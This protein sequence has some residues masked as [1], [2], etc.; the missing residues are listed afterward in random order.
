M[1]LYN[2]LY[3]LRTLSLRFFMVY[4]PRQ[5]R[6]GNY[7]VVTGKFIEKLNRGEALR[8]EGDGLQSRDFIHVNDIA[9]ALVLGYQSKVRGTVINVGNG[10]R[11]SVKALADIISSN[12]THV[13]AR[14]H[15]LRATLADT[16]RAKRLLSFSARKEMDVEIRKIAEQVKNGEDTM[17]IPVFWTWPETE[18][19]LTG[20]IE[21]W[22]TLNFEEKNDRIRRECEMNPKF[23]SEMVRLVRRNR[24]EEL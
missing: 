1:N 10:K 23:L 6:E 9:R 20:T 17:K 16:C 5:P 11:W 19:F 4:G 3:D 8:I 13:P 24:H 14:S 18:K 22:Q 15:D 21:Q 2:E 12:Q 7:A